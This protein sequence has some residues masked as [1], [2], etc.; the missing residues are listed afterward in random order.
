M[1]NS[2]KK[3]LRPRDSVLKEITAKCGNLCAF[4]GCSQILYTK[5]G[6]VFAEICHIEGVGGEGAPRY[7][8]SLSE[9]YLRSAENLILLCKN[10]HG[11]VDGR[12]K[13][14]T[15]DILRAMK[16]RHENIFTNPIGNYLDDE[17]IIKGRL[18]NIP[19]DINKFLIKIGGQYSGEDADYYLKCVSEFIYKLSFI[20]KNHRVIFGHVVNIIFQQPKVTGVNYNYAKWSL[21]KSRLRCSERDALDCFEVLKVNGLAWVDSEFFG[22]SEVRSPECWLNSIG[23]CDFWNDLQAFCASDKFLAGWMIAN[24]NF[25]PLASDE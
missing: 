14:Y 19:G 24:C 12:P 6:E 2:S 4:P 21:I 5:D 3:R 16:E 15:V 11:V 13:K 17:E 9:E 7:N 10:H 8:P 22:C 20:S 1:D 25:S 23:E 18:E